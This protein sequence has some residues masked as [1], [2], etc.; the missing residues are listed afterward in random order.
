MPHFDGICTIYEGRPRICRTFRC[1]LL[2]QV[3]AGAATSDE[4]RSLI[5]DLRAVIA[6]L[7]PAI[8]HPGHEMIRRIALFEH[9]H[10]ADLDTAE[11]RRTHRAL[12]LDIYIFQ[13]LFNR[14][15]DLPAPEKP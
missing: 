12:L 9:E 2:L 1:K 13:R 6:R 8:G 3:T 15:V 11:F 7:D 10:A 14:F 5:A 4:A